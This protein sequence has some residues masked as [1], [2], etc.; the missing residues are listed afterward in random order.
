M[1]RNVAALKDSNEEPVTITV[2][3]E[4]SYAIALA[5]SGP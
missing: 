5:S 2:S 1:V 3:V 4:E